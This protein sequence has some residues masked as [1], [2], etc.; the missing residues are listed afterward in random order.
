MRHIHSSLLK[1]L[2]ADPHVRAEQMGHTIERERVYDHI[3]QAPQGCHACAGE[4]DWCLMDS[5]GLWIFSMPLEVIEKME[6]ETGLEPAT[7]SLG[8]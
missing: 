4:G 3:T 6:R 2:D 5:I 1:E 7:S 8:I